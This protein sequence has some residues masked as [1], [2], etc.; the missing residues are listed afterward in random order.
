MRKFSEDQGNPFSPQ[1]RLKSFEYALHGIRSFFLSTPNAWIHLA[2]TVIVIVAAFYFELSMI[3]WIA[4]IYAIGLVFTAEALN[5]AVEDW[6]DSMQPNY[7]EKAGKVKDI[8]AGAVLIASI[9]AA[10]I[11]V[12]IFGSRIYELIIH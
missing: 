5:T 6:V 2:I 8:A 11:G 3:E 12:L 7:D 9:V 4:V 10:I 1:K